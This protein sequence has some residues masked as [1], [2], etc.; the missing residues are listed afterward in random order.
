MSGRGGVSLWGSAGSSLR[1]P[2]R[3][4]GEGTGLSSSGTGMGGR[5]R[6]PLPME[7][8]RCTLFVGGRGGAALGL[9]GIDGLGCGGQSSCTGMGAGG[10]S[11][12]S[13]C[14]PPTP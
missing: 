6:V 5:A 9:L 2:V 13:T 11:D 4:T 7:P 10:R 8:W 1:E 12:I 14:L 3:T